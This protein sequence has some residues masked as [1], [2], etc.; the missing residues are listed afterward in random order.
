MKVEILS[1]GAV[2]CLATLTV[3]AMPITDTVVFGDKEWAQVN[4][5]NSLS[6]NDISTV[7]PGGP[8][9]EGG[10]LNGWD[11]SGWTWATID[12]L[13]A[14]FQATT[15]HPGG[16][17]LVTE[18]DSAWAP[19]YFETIGFNPNF[20]GHGFRA[21][22]GLTLTRVI[23]TETLGAIASVTDGLEP[24][25]GDIVNTQGGMTPDAQSE[26]VGSWFF[27]PVTSVPEPATLPLLTLALSI[28]AWQ[29]RRWFRSAL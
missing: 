27:R 7:C 15:P 5:F 26:V 17:T 9:A 10:T 3:D 18:I 19:A 2:M 21:V 28:L 4:L 22:S 23:R 14:L 25:L 20:T 11:M 29:R 16:I 6:W 8:C 1:V 13:V 24:G 12:D